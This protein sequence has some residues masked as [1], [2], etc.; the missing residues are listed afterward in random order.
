MMKQ[1]GDNLVLGILGAGRE[2]TAVARLAL[3]AGYSVLIANSRGPESLALMVEILVP[4]A[5][6]A[7]A[8]EVAARSDIVHLALPL[9]HY[10]GIPSDLLAGKIVIDAMNYWAAGE[11]VLAEFEASP[12]RSSE[13]IQAF[14]SASRLV[15]TLNHISYHEL[16]EDALPVGTAGR[17]ALAIAGDDAEA[18][19]IVGKLV[20]DLGFD[21]L[22]AGP[23]S[24]GWRMGPGSPVFE[25]RFTLGELR[26]ALA[27][28]IPSN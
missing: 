12:P 5:V 25:G 19:K 11:G 16:E 21:S 17:R 4:G 1:R 13:K 8:K 28:A 15:K 24:E 7:S 23:L 20:S 18:K 26:R 3:K 27:L 6:A 2:G 14:L 9:S 10:R 22:D